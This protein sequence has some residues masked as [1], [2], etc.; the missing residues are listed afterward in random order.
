M[1]ELGALIYGTDEDEVSR[2]LVEAGIE[3][4]PSRE[5]EAPL[6]STKVDY[7]LA[8]LLLDGILM[9]GHTHYNDRQRKIFETVKTINLGKMNA[10]MVEKSSDVELL[11]RISQNTGCWASR[12][13]IFQAANGER[14]EYPLSTVSKDLTDLVGMGVL[15]RAKPPK[16]RSFG[17]YITTMAL[18]NAINLPTAKS[19]KDPVYE[20]KTVS[21][22]NP[23]T[24]R[25]DK[26]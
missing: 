5:P 17:Y 19:I 2:Y 11:A 1:V 13:N 18:N 21:V 8:R 25:V 26:I 15:E 4:D 16:K 10:A 7:H 14:P 24:G 6:V 23:L 9:A 22:V 3:K 20:G 12:E